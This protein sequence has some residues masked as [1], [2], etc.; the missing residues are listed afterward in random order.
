MTNQS[1]AGSVAL[2]RSPAAVKVDNL[3]RQALKVSDPYDAAQIAKGLRDHYAGEAGQL[4]R[5]R[6]GLPAVRGPM[7]VASAV[8]PGP[9]GQETQTAL[10]ELEIDLR[11]VTTDPGTKD[12]HPEM[13][14]WARAIRAAANE[15]LATA[16]LSLDPHQRD[17]AFAARRSLS[18]YARLSRYVGVLS[19]GLNNMYR[20]LAQCC[21]VVANLIL[22]SCGEALANGGVIRSSFILQ[23]PVSEMQMRRDAALNALRNLVGSTQY[24]HGPNEWPRGLEAYRQLMRRLDAAGLADL[25]ALFAEANLGRML[26]ELIDMAA[27]TNS[28]SLRAL[29]ATAQVTIDRINRLVAFCAS[30]GVA[31]DATNGGISPESPPLASFLSALKMFAEAFEGA[32]RGYRLVY[33]ARP[34]LLTYGLYGGQ[35]LDTETQTLLT[36][37]LLRNRLAEQVDCIS[38]CDCSIDAIRRQLRLDKLLFDTDRAIDYYA[39]GID[40]PDQMPD[41]A[42]TA[43][44]EIRAIAYGAL[45]ESYEALE[46]ALGQP[47]PAVFATLQ[48]IADAL[49]WPRGNVVPPPFNNVPNLDT[50]LTPLVAD[51][52]TRAQVVAHADAV[53]AA[54]PGPGD[55]DFETQL[56]RAADEAAA[57]ANLG[58]QQTAELAGAIA[59]V[60]R[61][62]DLYGQLLHQELCMQEV[63]EDQWAKLVKALSPRCA[64]D[65]AFPPGAPSIVVAMLNDAHNRINTVTVTRHDECPPVRVSIP[66][67]FE[68]SWDTLVNNVLKDGTNR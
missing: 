12:Y 22:V 4:E 5:E 6:L 37:V 18:E 3:L 36:L 10:D 14:G 68:T 39:V 35:G 20:S 27:S 31:T 16:R 9:A 25:R 29:G 63:Q 1:Q 7:V 59:Q 23:A 17:R 52:A 54:D 44:G 8:Q 50:A 65:I 46:T 26:D 45:M 32:N 51:G 42:E 21:D 66:P 15:G 43:P 49:G 61:D 57:L 48:R 34:S 38:R 24:A 28:N 40:S 30:S 56:N 53:I 11:Q 33:I 64:I 67:N 2:D 58:A 47:D 60:L 62:R 13:Q 19:S 41:E 55:V